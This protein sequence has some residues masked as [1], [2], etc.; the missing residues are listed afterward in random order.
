MNN[1]FAGTTGWGCP[2]EKFPGGCGGPCTLDG[3]DILKYWGVP[4]WNKWCARPP[5]IRV[6]LPSNVTRTVLIM[7]LGRVGVE[8][9]VVSVALL[10]S[11]CCR[12]VSLVVLAAWAIFYR[13]CFYAACKVKE[14][15]AR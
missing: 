3:S 15:W 10:R 4:E 7:L 5:C 6:A 2:C 12:Y 9:E 13:L 1:E 8:H 11:C 14:S